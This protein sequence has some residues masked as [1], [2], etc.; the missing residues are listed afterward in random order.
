MIRGC[1]AL[2][3][4][5][6]IAG[7]AENYVPDD[8]VTRFQPRGAEVI[9]YEEVEFSAFL[10]A[11][12]GAMAEL[13]TARCTL[14]YRGQTVTITPPARIAL[15]ILKGAQPA[16]TSRC[17]VAIGNR[18]DVVESS[19]PAQQPTAPGKGRHYAEKISALFKQ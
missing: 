15:P 4:V 9:A 6:L 16:L 14:R 18:Q 7:C 17:E 8:T 2:A 19:H 11:R 5:T 10:L 1:L 13:N 12:G 3:T